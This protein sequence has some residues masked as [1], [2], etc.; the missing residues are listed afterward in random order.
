VGSWSE[1]GER[2]RQARLASGLTQ[3]ELAERV[4]F[5][6]SALVRVEG[7]GRRLDAMELFRLSDAL[8]LPVAH[9]VTRPPA[10][11]VSRR[12]ALPESPDV[13]ARERYLVDADLETHLA[14]TRWLVDSD[15]LVPP[16]LDPPAR[17]ATAAD[18]RA[19]AFDARAQLGLA[20]VDPLGPAADACE[21]FGLYILVVDRDADGASLLDE[22]FGVAVIGGRA[23]PGRRRFT[24]AH[25]L[26]HHLLGDAYTSDLGVATSSDEREAVVDA[27]ASE[28]LLPVSAAHAAWER[29]GSVRDRLVWLAGT[30][31]VSWSVAVGAARREGL[32]SDQD[33]SRMRADTPRRGEFLAAVGG[34]PAADLLLGQVGANWQ[35]AVLAGWQRGHLTASRTVE[36]LRGRLQADDL[37]ERPPYEDI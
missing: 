11:V 14:D 26:G 27:F 10:A 20:P 19:L 13:A 3:A 15:L 7:G 34:E 6:R 22:R 12:A 18:A 5:E 24:A 9:F 33:W 1:V 35:R 30:F 36:L 21:Q 2:V 23:E 8:G 37:P 31:R 28:L 17:I 29:G 16:A 4:G 25:E 32:V